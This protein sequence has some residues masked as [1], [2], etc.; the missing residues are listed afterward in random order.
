MRARVAN[1]SPA[2]LAVAGLAL[3]GI[4]VA[5]GLVP[6]DEYA[7]NGSLAVGS[8]VGVCLLAALAY[9]A[10]NTDP[11]WLITAAVVLWP[12]N[13]SWRYFGFPGG[14]APDRMLLL[15]GFAAL[16][17]RAPAAR[18]RPLI[19]GKP[20]HVLF[21]LT[22]CWTVGSGIAAA[23]LTQSTSTFLILDRMIVPFVV[24]LL[25]PIAFRTPRHRQ[26]LLAALVGFGLYDALMTLFQS[27]GLDSLIFPRFIVDPS[28]GYHRRFDTVRARGPFL[29]AGVN[30]LGLYAYGVAAAVAFVSWRGRWTRVLAARLIAVPRP[31][32][33]A[34]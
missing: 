4:V 1:V 17:L 26:V 12:F 10:W 29:E 24:F 31:V 7:H 16:V 34:R 3:V 13:S 30:G 22:V 14:V 15:A 32:T 5:L 19:V 25:A 9:L 8:V 2:T 28:V 23:T 18:D 6:Y 11:A 21:A 33:V 20:I 27:V